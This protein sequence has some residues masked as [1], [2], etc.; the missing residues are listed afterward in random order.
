MSMST[1]VAIVIAKTPEERAIAQEAHYQ[2]EAKRPS[3]S[4]VINHFLSQ[5]T[6]INEIK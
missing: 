4:E 1:L 2:S 3:D 6:L 5:C